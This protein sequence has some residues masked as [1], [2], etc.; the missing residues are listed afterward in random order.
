MGYSLYIERGRG[1][2]AITLAEWI[3]AVEDADHF[4]V[5]SGDLEVENP[6]SHERLV[7]PNTGGDVEVLLSPNEWVRALSWSARGVISFRAELLSSH[8]SL[9]RPLF[10]LAQKLE[11]RVV[12]D[13]GESYTQD[14]F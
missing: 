2:T 9:V 3:A 7:I 12:G 8:R 4:R 11:A 10:A 6:R 13:E 1:Q 5:A 14:D